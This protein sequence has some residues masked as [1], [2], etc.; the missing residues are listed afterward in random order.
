MGLLYNLVGSKSLHVGSL[1][2]CFDVLMEGID[3]RTD[4]YTCHGETRLG[5]SL[6]PDQCPLP[7]VL[8]WFSPLYVFS[9]Y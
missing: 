4:L 1:N 6:Y 3:S 5:K 2:G 8:L 9:P 7:W